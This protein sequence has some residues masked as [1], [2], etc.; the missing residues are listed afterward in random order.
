[1][2]GGCINVKSSHVDPENHIE[3]GS[4]THEMGGAPMGADPKNSVLNKWC[5]AHDVPNLFVTDG[6]AM[7]SCSTQNPSLTY[8]A[9]T[10]RAADHAA[11]LLLDG[12]FVHHGDLPFEV[13]NG[14]IVG[15]TAE[16]VPTRYLTTV[17]E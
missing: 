5:Q 1:M 10:V 7:S 14:E 6:A 13:R 17:D 12:W 2:A 4:R 3:L 16:G 8:M 11:S 9:L 15:A